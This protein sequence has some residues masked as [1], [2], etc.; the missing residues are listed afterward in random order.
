MEYLDVSGRTKLTKK[1]IDVI[2]DSSNCTMLRHLNIMGCGLDEEDIVGLIPKM[3]RVQWKKKIIGQL[4][5]PRK[6]HF[7]FQPVYLQNQRSILSSKHKYLNELKL[8]HLNEL[9]VASKTL[10]N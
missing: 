9:K 4:Y 8:D 2:A 10:S 7:Y 5:I 1:S 3:E 6:G